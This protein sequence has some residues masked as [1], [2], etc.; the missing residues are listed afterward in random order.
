MNFWTNIF[1]DQQLTDIDK[2][3]EDIINS[4]PVRD[5]SNETSDTDSSQLI[6][7]LLAADDRFGNRDKIKNNPLYKDFHDKSGI[8]SEVNTLLDKLAIQP[9]RSNRYKIYEEIY[10]TIPMIKKMMKT[11]L[12]NLIQKNPVTG[13]SLI[14]REKGE[15]L[16]G[17]H[18]IH[19][20]EEYENRKVAA[21]SFVDEIID[22]FDLVN[23][24]KYRILP[25]QQMY[26]DVF[27][28]IINLQDFSLND[29]NHDNNSGMGDEY[30]LGE[31]TINVP[32]IDVKNK[33][34]NIDIHKKLINIQEKVSSSNFKVDDV[35]DIL[36]EVFLDLDFFNVDEF[37]SEDQFL[38]GD[39]FRSKKTIVL[40][41]KT[42]AKNL[43]NQECFYEY[44]QNNAGELK[45]F[46]RF[47]KNQK[48]KNDEE[49]KKRGRPPKKKVVTEDGESFENRMQ[50]INV[51]TTL[52]VSN[53][54]M[55]I[56]QPKNIVILETSYGTVLGYVEVAEKENIQ[57]TNITQQLSSIIGRIVSV[58][59][60]SVNSQE[61]IVARIVKTLIKK[62]IQQS[63][64]K[65]KNKDNLDKVLNSLA[66]EV[67]NT[68]KKLI[69]ETDKDNP[70]RNTF[71]KLKARFIPIDRMFHFS[72]PSP[73]FYPYGASFIDPLILPGK[74]YIL[75]Q[76][77]N[78]I[79][80]LSRAAPV[81]KW[82]VD[83]GATQDHNKY[84][85]QLK[86]DMYNQRVTIDNVLSFKSMPK[87]LSDFK[88]IAVY[89]K[90]GVSHLDMEVQSLG[91][92][93]VKV[94]DLEDAR[95]ELIA[96]SGIPAPYLGYGD[97]VDLQSQLVH[98]NLAFATEI[99]DIQETVA[100]ELN[101][102]IDYIAKILNYQIKP[103]DY[104]EVALIPP[105][106]LMLQLIEMTAGSASNIL[107]VFQNLQLPVDPINFLKKYVPF[108][109]WDE[110]E[111]QAKRYNAEKSSEIEFKAKADARL[112]QETMAIQQGQSM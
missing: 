84:I 102:M 92:A 43:D 86:R 37:L 101:R 65:N 95:R 10:S 85:Q 69:I 35:C 96:L 42:V 5:A 29:K 87:I 52:D 32:K 110:F 112:Q 61:E 18:S 14:I 90:G 40:K 105:V 48:E 66:P 77:S 109:N 53:V 8:M 38:L 70:K 108:V 39:D 68:I 30:F 80:K 27:V 59:N 9:D 83:V 62:I 88:D 6:H 19:H 13:K 93:S 111:E 56:H 100:K 67:C 75:A 60:N 23:K 49:I 15:E 73:D 78:I 26:G 11:W 81:R 54:V 74:L 21:R 22:F 44:L 36:A 45:P 64:Q 57:V 76:L 55:L 50:K 91:D 51:N 4:V 99:A 7:Q 94:Q 97:V 17:N 34:K 12:S 41:E 58:S 72:A 20:D 82:I 47:T 89:R 25:H 107:G 103:S 63:S 71:R 98:V 104:V 31:S 28:E 79:M 2:K 33:K 16:G 46:L 24:L 1:S 3:I 106:V